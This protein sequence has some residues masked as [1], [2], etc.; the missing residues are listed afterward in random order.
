MALTDEGNGGIPA[1]MLVGPTGYAGGMPYPVYQSGG[2]NGGFGSDGWWVILL[3]L[4]LGGGWGNG[5]GGGFGG[6]QL[7]YDF[8]WVLNGQ[9]LFLFGMCRIN[10][11]GV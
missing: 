8:P 7:G 6:N 11:L 3:L 4:A 1:T 10:N 9:A 2:G 5:F